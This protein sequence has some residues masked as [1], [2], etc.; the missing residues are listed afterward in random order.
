MHIEE[1]VDKLVQQSTGYSPFTIRT[2]LEAG[3]DAGVFEFDKKPDS[4]EDLGWNP[5]MVKCVGERN[6]QRV[7]ILGHD[8][9]IDAT[10]VFH[11]DVGDPWKGMV[12]WVLDEE[13]YP[14]DT[15]VLLEGSEFAG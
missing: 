1:A 14:T 12:E 11:H 2:I 5:D 3:E 8:E 13:L 15:K 7:T 9:R 4:M 10:L 6:N